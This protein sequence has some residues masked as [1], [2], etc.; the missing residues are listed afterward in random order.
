MEINTTFISPAT[1]IPQAEQLDVANLTHAGFKSSTKD[2]PVPCKKVSGE[3]ERG[4]E[5][6]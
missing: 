3:T 6:K 2:L 4:R 1:G 5:M